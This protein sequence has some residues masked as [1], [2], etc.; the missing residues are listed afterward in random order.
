MHQKQT[1]AI[2][3][4]YN[5]EQNVGRVIE[6]LKEHDPDLDIVVID[7]GSRDRTYEVARSSGAIAIRLP[8]NLGIGGAVQT[9]LIFARDHGYQTAVQVDG[10]G[11]HKPEEIP[12][13]LTPVQ[14]GETDV[15]IGSRF[16]VTKSFRSTAL[17][18]LG[19]SIFRA[20][21]F[22]ATKQVITDNTSG[23]RAFNRKAIVFLADNYPCDYPEVEVIV[24]L[25]RNGFRLKEFPVEMEER[26]GGRSSITP[27][28]SAYYMIKV[29]L[30]ILVS[31][32]RARESPLGKP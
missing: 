4:A 28:K 19:I 1:L 11:Q 30:A 18:R 5:E 2:I 31:A 26:Q 22:L 7:D 15:A 20:A 21:L 17:R 27:I 32:L 12:T 13:I 16:L 10:D 23:F 9:G 14:N 25:K 8:H 24:S 3:P 6:S 29:L